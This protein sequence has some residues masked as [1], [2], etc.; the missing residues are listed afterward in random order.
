MDNLKMCL[1]I[2]KKAE[3]FSYLFDPVAFKNYEPK[4]ETFNEV[5][6]NYL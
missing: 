3:V 5:K 4:E 6:K 2:L 1:K